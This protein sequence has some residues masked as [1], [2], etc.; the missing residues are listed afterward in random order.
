M[1]SRVVDSAKVSPSLRNMILVKLRHILGQQISSYLNR[2]NCRRVCLQTPGWGGQMKQRSASKF[3][4]H[5]WKHASCDFSSRR[6]FPQEPWI[7]NHSSWV[8]L[9]FC[10]ISELSKFSRNHYRL[11]NVDFTPKVL[12]NLLWTELAGLSLI[13]QAP[14]SLY[15]SGLWLTGDRFGV[16]YLS[17]APCWD[18]LQPHCAAEHETYEQKPTSGIK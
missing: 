10:W 7:L 17:S 6:L 11:D 3:K 1:D 16:I 2:I 4:P 18:R 13:N 15:V 5:A 9:Q 14:V 12:V 8:C